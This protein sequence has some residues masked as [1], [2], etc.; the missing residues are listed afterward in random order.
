MCSR[1]RE[2]ASLM[3]TTLDDNGENGHVGWVDAWDPAGLGE[4]FRFVLLQFF[5]ALESNRKAP[6]IFEPSWDEDVFI[7]LG[8]FSGDVLLADVPFV[9]LTDLNLLPNGSRDGTQQG[10]ALPLL[11]SSLGSR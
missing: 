5:T 10:M 6:I 8:P 11:V 4:V 1:A 9:P 7:A 2:F 3:V